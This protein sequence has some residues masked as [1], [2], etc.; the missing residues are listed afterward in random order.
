LH[1]WTRQALAVQRPEG[2][3]LSVQADGHLLALNYRETPARVVLKG[4]FR[5]TIEPYGMERVGLR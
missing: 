2:V 1:R 5:R 4:V 3:F